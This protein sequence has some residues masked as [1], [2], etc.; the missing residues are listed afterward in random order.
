MCSVKLTANTQVILTIFMVF[1]SCF[2]DKRQ[3]LN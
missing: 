1:H 2:R 3:C